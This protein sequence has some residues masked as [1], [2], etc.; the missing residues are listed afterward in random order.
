[1][2][3]KATEGNNIIYA[4]AMDAPSLTLPE[5]VSFD[6]GQN[7][8]I[9]YVV[10]QVHYK[11]VDQFKPPNNHK[12]SSGLTIITS[13]VPTPRKAGVYL[14]LTDGYIPSHSIE[15][16]EVACPMTEE[17]E[18]F[19]FGFR[20]HAHTLGRVISGYRVRNNTWE[21]I[22]RKDPRLPEM[23][24]NVTN[25]GM[26]IQKGDILAARCTMENTLDKT[27]SIGST[28]NDEMCNFYIMYY[29]ERSK[30]LKQNSCFSLG[31]PEWY[32]NNYQGLNLENVPKTVSV[33]PGSDH[34]LIRNVTYLP[35]PPRDVED[36]NSENLVD[37]TEEVIDNID[38][39]VLEDIVRNLEEEEQ[40]RELL[41]KWQREAM[42][43]D[44]FNEV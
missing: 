12:D 15:Y 26:N 41:S 22:G 43:P 14:M 19:P 23:F 18:L 35:S 39:Q 31:P 30:L 36:T 27:V 6:V 40:R 5:G 24:Y 9:K 34:P 7:T 38:P 29:V 1:M 44:Y 10:V 25:P 8:P 20:T 28:Q 13:T 21:E 11:N 17:V 3:I 2:T 4:W 42:I 16:F 37:E 33:I 32:W